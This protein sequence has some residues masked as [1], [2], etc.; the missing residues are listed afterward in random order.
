MSSPD[1]TQ[2]PAIVVAG[3]DDDLGVAK[4]EIG[5]RYGSDYDVRCWSDPQQAVDDLRNLRRDGREVALILVGAIAAEQPR[6]LPEMR[7]LHPRAKRA[8]LLRWGDLKAGRPV[9]DALARGDLDHFT[10][11]PGSRG[12][13]YFHHALTALLNAWAELRRPSYEVVQIIGDPTSPRS[14]ALRDVLSRYHVPFGFY[15]ATSSEGRMLLA[16]Y[17]LGP[18]PRLPIVSLRFRAD[19]APLQDPSDREIADAFGVDVTLD[20]R[21]TFDLAIV[22]A[23]PAGLAAAVSA[24][25]ER[26]DTVVIERQAIGGQAGTTSLIRNY[27]GFSAGVSGSFLANAMFT[28]AWGLGAR[29]LFMREVSSFE[30]EE[31]GAL[32]LVFRDGM[33]LRA[34]SVLFAMGV[35]YRRLEAPG[36]EELV[37][38][39]VFYTPALSEVRGLEGRPVAVVGGG[40]SAGQA[41]MHLSSYASSVT[42][43][44]R[45]PSLAQSMSEYL[46]RA[47]AEARNVTVRFR[48]EVAGAFGAGRL[49]RITVRDVAGGGEEPLEAAA[50]FVLIGSEPRTEWLEGVVA[51]DRWGFVL[52]G[53]DAGAT[54]GFAA[55]VPG[56]FAA[57][58]VRAGS[59]K[60]VASAVGEG[61]VVISQVHAHLASPR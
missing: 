7:S 56:V 49:E 52:V 39:G 25:S 46:I 42:L 9:L 54:Q 27:P 47:L 2:L 5:R 57:G 26:I 61:A 50:L 60:R 23:G 19:L 51:L 33:F 10:L 20:G 22:G 21:H 18:S 48:A 43:L 4:S 29:F 36:V 34:R 11:R 37:G 13:V 17:G 32:R 24:S 30:R 44:V 31:D 6:L 55:S 35:S 41:A 40:N 59:V 3:S 28:Q 15:D 45:G 12:D 38:R 14:I 53:A 8:A 16:D 58:D 1:E